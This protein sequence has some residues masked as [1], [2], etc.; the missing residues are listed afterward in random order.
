MSTLNANAIAIIGIGCRLPGAN[1]PEQFWRNLC[2]GVESVRRFSDEELRAAG[3]DPSALASPDYVRAG[4]V[5]EDIDRFD[6]AFFGL[7]PREADVLD[8]QQR[9]LLECAYHAL[10]DAGCATPDARGDIGVYVGVS[11]SSYAQ[12]QLATRPDLVASMGLMALSIANGRDFVAAQLA[13]RL[14][15]TGPAVGVSTACSTSLVAV[16]AA[17][18][19]LL[20][21]EC[22]AALA[23]G[24]SLRSLQIEGYWY[25]EGGVLSPDGHCRPF[26]AD[27]RGTVAGNGAAIV[28]LKRLND[29]LAACDPIYAVIIG[30]AINNDGADKLGFTAPS[31]SGQSRVIREAIAIAGVEP[32]TLG[33][34]EAHGTATPL[35][36]PVE[37]AALNDALGAPN[38]PARCLLGSVKS[39][40]GHL[41][42]AAGVAGLIKAALAVET[43]EVP[44]TLHFD[45]PNT[46]IDFDRS[47]F[48]VADRRQPW[49]IP[50]RRRAGVS[51]FGIGGT[52]AHLV[53]EQADPVRSGPTAREAQLLTASARCAASLEAGCERLLAHVDGWTGSAL[54]DV[55][56]TMSIRPAYAERAARVVGEGSSTWWRGRADATPTVAWLFPGQGAQH[57]GMAQALY[58]QEPVF[59]ARLDACSDWIRANAGWDLVTLLY[60]DVDTQEARER[61][62]TRTDRTQL[63]LFAVEYSLAELWRSLGHH[64][65]LMLGHSLGE[66]AVACIAGVMDLHTALTL[67]EARGRLVA[68]LP[69]GAML[70]VSIGAEASRPLIGGALD[71]AADNTDSSVVLSGPC[72]AIDDAERQF[73]ARGVRTQ[74]LD[75]SHAFHS[76]MLDPLLDEFRALLD[77]LPLH[78]PRQPY[79]SSATGRLAGNEVT[80]A[81]HWVQ[82]LRGTVR[83]REAVATLR[84]QAG[85]TWYL[86]VGPSAVASL[87]VRRNGIASERSVPSLPSRHEGR[88]ARHV[89]LEAVARLWTCGVELDLTALHGGEQRRRARLP[90]YAFARTRHWIEAGRNAGL[91]HDP[92]EGPLQRIEWTRSKAPRSV[93]P[94]T[95][96]GVT[97]L[98]IDDDSLA[99]LGL[100]FAPCVTL[101]FGERLHPAVDGSGTL[102]TGVAAD[103]VAVLERIASE[104]GV[105]ARIVYA[106]RSGEGMLLPLQL[107]LLALL[108]A[109]RRSDGSTIPLQLVTRNA[110]QVGG[111][112]PIDPTHRALAALAVVAAQEDPQLRLGIIDLGS[113]TGVDQLAGWIDGTGERVQRVALRGRRGW[114]A[115]FRHAPRGH[116]TPAQAFGRRRIVV[117]G[118]LGN[119]AVELCAALAAHAARLVVLGRRPEA[120]LDLQGRQRLHR[121]RAI[122]AVDYRAIDVRDAATL[123]Q[124]LREI[125]FA[126]GQ[127]DLLLH[128]AASMDRSTLRPIQQCTTDDLTRQNAAK[129]DGTRALQIA[130]AALGGRR[131]VLMSSLAGTL[132][133]VGMG[134]Y[135]AAN[136]YMDA[137]AEA[138]DLQQLGWLAIGWDGLAHGVHDGL[139]ADDVT[140]ALADLV[141]GDECGSWLVSLQPVAARWD[142]WFGEADGDPPVPAARERCDGA[143][144]KSALTATEREVA[145]TYEALI[146]VVPIGAD[147]DFFALGGDS[148]LATQVCSRLRRHF[149]VELPIAAVFEHPRVAALAARIDALRGDGEDLVDDELRALVERLADVDQSTLREL[150]SE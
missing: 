17:C 139:S 40:F 150:L 72:A 18:A 106:P 89:W 103:A 143:V 145:A 27:A 97:L 54:A 31:V 28:M 24:A 15:L 57:V 9:I 73:A 82:H 42:V 25:Q 87:L 11:S 85:D 104:L 8:P 35:G 60:G 141:D 126:H 63:A 102:R 59:R 47:R 4:A 58:A 92:G 80:C 66:Y 55:A 132:G 144:P 119:A 96:N 75:V 115:G 34:I 123:T 98:L 6:G 105:V 113:R 116:A 44:A 41:D 86:D 64:P 77:T 84:A 120:T 52:N 146:G 50:G 20:N 74:R 109:G 101:R 122:A 94:A 81:E 88:S 135:A 131:V 30:S 114:R 46:K 10:E 21:F 68:T 137:Q 127:I 53:L 117:I 39:N 23:G 65:S 136:A 76:A 128:A 29:A 100:A 32:D 45:V 140:S 67:V 107:A 148:L 149:G 79:V 12:T 90:G 71:L 61:E 133:G 49:P 129:V 110:W 93:G 13:Y 83:F 36:D 7:T 14:N 99:K 125:E 22:D 2:D 108:A 1:S 19:A 147:D 62:L 124:C 5:L 33:Y 51:S 38:G 26:S 78:P 91:T 3:V 121:L 111:D 118:G 130:T 37:I 69:R 43:G 16:H 134:A 142:R 56:H 95:R 112:E 70:S 48:S 138:P